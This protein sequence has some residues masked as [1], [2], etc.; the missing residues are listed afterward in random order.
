MPAVG[1][2]SGSRRVAV[3][4]APG[5]RVLPDLGVPVWG[6]SGRG[7]PR[8]DA[9]EP[10]PPPRR[11][12]WSYRSYWIAGSKGRSWKTQRLALSPRTAWAPDVWLFLPSRAARV[13]GKI[14]A[15][16]PG[17]LQGRKVARPGRSHA[18]C[19]PALTAEDPRREAKG[20]CVF[21][22]FY[23]VAELLLNKRKRKTHSRQA[24]GL[25]RQ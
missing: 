2:S 8:S 10:P 12:A 15:V 22:D 9:P 4:G 17:D 25:M 5:R 3:W 6:P 19:R 24:K 13:P 18:P 7:A 11:P 16:V 14:W 1:Q 23:F 21:L 20:E